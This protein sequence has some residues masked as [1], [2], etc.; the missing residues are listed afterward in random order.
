MKLRQLRTWLAPSL[1]TCALAAF[2]LP[3]R[4]DYAVMRNGARLHV[5]GYLREGTNIL[6]Y[7]SGGSVLVPASEVVRFE[8]EDRF[9]PVPR[10]DSLNVPFAEKIREAAAQ[11]GVDERL[12]SSVI[13][14]ESNF[15]PTAVSP[16]HAEGLMQLM[17]ETAEKYDVRNAFDPSQNIMA[18]SRYLKQLLDEYHG[19][20]SLALAAYNAG[21][22][23][24]AQYGGVPPFPETQNYIRHV[25]KKLQ[26]LK[27]NPAL[28]LQ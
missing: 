5:A 21:P 15:Q 22:E 9:T 2:A 18:G 19:N 23:R 10:Q 6:L 27:A 14:A 16:K 24:V 26:E 7:V 1:L 25:T 13:S 8:P 3:A 11:S 17:P 28:A 20:L 4:A 12:I